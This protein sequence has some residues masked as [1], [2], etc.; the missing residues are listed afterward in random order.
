MPFA[1]LHMGPG[2]A[3]KAAF[4]RHFSI[5]VFGLTRISL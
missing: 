5:V 3:V 2:M 1:P 4:P